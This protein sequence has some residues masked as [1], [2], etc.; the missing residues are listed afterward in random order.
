MT[1]PDKKIL[2]LVKE[3]AGKGTRLFNLPAGVSGAAE[4]IT[5]NRQVVGKYFDPALGRY[6]DTANFSIH[7]SESGAYIRPEKP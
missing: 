2:S 4:L 5:S 3:H 7:Y 1:L 6:V